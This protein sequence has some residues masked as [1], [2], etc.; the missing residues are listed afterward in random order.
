MMMVDGGLEGHDDVMG[1]EG[2]DVMGLEGALVPKVT[3]EYTPLHLWPDDS[4]EL[5]SQQHGRWSGCL[6]FPNDD[7]ISSDKEGPEI[8]GEAGDEVI[9]L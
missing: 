8:R 3:I 2:H 6:T 5:R 7:P 4:L 1:L 9:G